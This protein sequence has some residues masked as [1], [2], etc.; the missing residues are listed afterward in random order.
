MFPSFTPPPGAKFRVFEK[1]GVCPPV[2]GATMYWIDIV[3]AGQ[4]GGS[5]SGS[6]ARG[7]CAGGRW[8]GFLHASGFT[9]PF[10]VVVGVGGAGA[11]GAAT[12]SGSVGG[13]SSFGPMVVKGASTTNGGG[14]T[15]PSPGGTGWAGAVV[16]A[17]SG[18]GEYGGGS[19]SNTGAAG[20]GSV[21]GAGAGGGITSSTLSAAGAHASSTTGAGA[22]GTSAA[23]AVLGI[24]GTDAANLSQCGGG[25]GAAYSTDGTSAVGGAG[26][27]PGGGGGGAGVA[28]GASATGGMGGNGRVVVYW[29]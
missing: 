3:S 4:G 15:Q 26:G 9:N 11:I 16:G 10:A 24:K 21:F 27:F 22:A 28:S 25:G 23:G 7:G 18:V 5:E 14:L 19:G 12:V 6:V 8:S 13:L 29:W 2:A 17:S 20:G 1:S